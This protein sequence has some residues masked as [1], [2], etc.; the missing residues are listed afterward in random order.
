[1]PYISNYRDEPEKSQYI[2]GFPKGVNNIQDRSLIDNKQ[3]I[4][5]D[6]AVLVVDGVMR[7][8]G[9][10]K[11]YNENGGTK[12]LGQKPFYIKTLS[13]RY[14]VR[15][16]KTANNTSKLQYLVGSNWTDI[17][18]GALTGNTDAYLV[19]A[20]NKMFVYNGHDNLRYLNTSLA[21][22]TYTALNS[23]TNLTVTA[24]GTTGSTVY[25]Y[26]V[27]AF[28]STGETEAC[29]RVQIS[30]GNAT[31]STTNYNALS[32]NAVT[33]ADGYNIYGRTP[34]GYEEVYLATVYGVT[35]YNDTGTATPVTSKLAPETNSTGGIKAK[36]ALF[37]LGR[38]F[39]AGIT[40]GGT[41][42]PTR[43]AYS[44]VL[45]YV[46]TYAGGE[47]GG[48]WVE[49]S[50]NDGGEIVGLE[51]YQNGVIVFKTN[52]IFKFYFTSTGLPAVEEITKDNGGT[53]FKASQSIGNNVVYV[54]Q[55]E[56]KI[57]VYSLGQQENFSTDLIRT[58]EVSIFIANGLTNV[59]RAYLSNIATFYM[60]YK[61]GFTYTTVGNTENS[62]GWLIDTRFGGWV[63]WDGL[64]MECSNYSTYDDGT[65][66]HLY[67][68][69][70]SDGYMI[71]LFEKDTNDNGL[72]YKT[73]I[74]TKHF[75]GGQFDIEKVWRNPVLWFKYISG[76]TIMTEIW[77]DGT[78]KAGTA[79]LA[80]TSSGM[81]MGSDLF[82]TFTFGHTAVSVPEVTVNADTP[83]Q[84]DMIQLSRSI[85]FYLIDS[86]KNTNW[87]FMGLR[88]LFS[89]LE[90][91]PLPE[92]FRV[93]LT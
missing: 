74:G 75:N 49:I 48:G 40:E 33:G 69:S 28:N 58:N 25:S 20:R 24:T 34:Y 10:V 36:F 13:T 84:I 86:Q 53:S 92:T 73:T 89:P 47:Y 65:N 54:G 87:L 79:N 66:I 68:G 90:G 22:T 6:N 14:W 81:G 27:S 52:G 37:T 63:K 82:G 85:G 76:G 43:L 50:S 2:I 8:P 70:N 72:A 42:Y 32:W 29:A 45:D 77:V 59:N 17:P 71:R 18:S 60:D 19:Q 1:M 38:Q 62:E 30:N 56:N 15:V 23:V 46:D 39:A 26:R 78:R 44:G 7:R 12:V 16:V 35:S 4:Q 31:L 61:F 83:Q 21:L 91:K 11:V 55:K 51:S 88:L 9:S 64:P 41:Y 80:S 3:L 67:G 5:A 93:E 57:C